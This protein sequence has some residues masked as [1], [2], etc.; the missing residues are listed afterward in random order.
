MTP[1][2][3]HQRILLHELRTILCDE[4]RAGDQLPVEWR[5]VIQ[6]DPH[7]TAPY[8][9][10]ADYLEDQGSDLGEL[11]R[12]QCELIGEKLPWTD[13]PL[14]EHPFK[15]DLMVEQA[16]ETEV[17]PLINLLSRRW[18]IT[19]HLYG[20]RKCSITMKEINRLHYGIVGSDRSEREINQLV[21][22]H[23]TQNGFDL[24][25]PWRD[26]P[27]IDNRRWTYKQDRKLGRTTRMLTDVLR[28]CCLNQ[29]KG[30]RISIRHHN[31]DP[32]ALRKVL[33]KLVNELGMPAEE[34]GPMFGNSIIMHF[35]DPSWDITFTDHA[36]QHAGIDPATGRDRTVT[37]D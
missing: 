24:S 25:R 1:E 15:V 31:P 34:G 6:A 17:S 9:I 29:E 28:Y 19:A 5:E 27:D 20:P 30:K 33:Y 4:T 14:P 37:Q 13:T 36:V 8:L 11:C 2:T 10:L 16:G 7:E 23:L 21:R 32:K 26:A 22:S 35:D 3:L 18:E 12:I